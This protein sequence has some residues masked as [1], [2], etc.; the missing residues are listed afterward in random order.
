MPLTPEDKI[1]LIKII[2]LFSSKPTSE[3]EYVISVIMESKS[4][5]E[6]KFKLGRK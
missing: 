3:K 4:F 6:L 2:A 1:L 5:E